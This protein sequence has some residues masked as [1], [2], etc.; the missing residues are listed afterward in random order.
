MR[1]LPNRSA[2]PTDWNA[3]RSRVAFTMVEIS[4]V[5]VIV[6]LLIGSISVGRS[7]LRSS[8]LQSIAKEHTLFVVAISSFKEIYGSIP[9]D[10]TNATD[11]W[12]IAA[13][14]TGNNL[15][16]RNAQSTD[17]KTCNGD[18]DLRIRTI[19]TQGPES[20]R[21]WQHLNN[22]G[23]ISGKY[24]GA[25]Y[26]EGMNASNSPSGKLPNS[27]WGT[28][29]YVTQS[30]SPVGFFDGVYN[31]TLWIGGYD[32]TA[33]ASAPIMN[34]GEMWNLDVKVDDGM[35]AIGKLVVFSSNNIMDECSDDSGGGGGVTKA[36]LDAEYR[37]DSE[38]VA[39]L[40][41]FRDQ[42]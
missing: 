9:G 6:G 42:F 8:Q 37:L 17:A 36:T 7:M 26:S 28:Y 40:P 14:I 22:A 19:I 38:L 41:V 20:M 25:Y 12:G 27:L 39:C 21:F 35:P 30:S 18:G 23:L 24:T 29:D 3:F 11:Y 34:G 5:L 13:G 15:T 31:N 33:T 2:V 16:C 10:M 1:C 4:L 32:S